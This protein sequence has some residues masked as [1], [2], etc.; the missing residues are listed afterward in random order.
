M[1]SQEIPLLGDGQKHLPRVLTPLGGRPQQLKSPNEGYEEKGPS[2]V[3]RT[4][5]SKLGY[6]RAAAEPE[7]ADL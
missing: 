3:I 2:D 4:E 7:A 5:L 6:L 1:S